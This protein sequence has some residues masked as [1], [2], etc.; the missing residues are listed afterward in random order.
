MGIAWGVSIPGEVLTECTGTRMSDYHT[1]PDCMMDIQIRGHRYYE[2]N[3]GIPSTRMLR[4]DLGYFCSS[5]L[6]LPVWFPPD[7]VPMPALGRSGPHVFNSVEDLRKAQPPPNI[8]AAGLMPLYLRQYSHMLAHKPENQRLINMLWFWSHGPWTT[9]VLLRGAELFADAR[10]YPGEVHRF[11]EIVT[12]TL[13]RKIEFGLRLD[14]LPH[15]FV[16]TMRFA[17]DFAGMM[18]PDMFRDFAIRYIGIILERFRVK[19]RRLHIE[20]LRPQHLPVLMELGL[21]HFDAGTGDGLT[22]ADLRNLSGV[23]CTLQFK[24]VPEL[25]QSTPK[26]IQARYRQ[27]LAEGATVMEVELCRGVPRENLQ[28]FVEVARNYE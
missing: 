18:S 19:K 28:A 5:L 11:L 10:N 3:Y 8:E 7:N 16:E 17:D 24:T 27:M 13:I 15:D 12:E 4:V 26:A 21:S 20:T 6:G 23:C 9:A 2:E 1:R 25:L 22:L 14:G